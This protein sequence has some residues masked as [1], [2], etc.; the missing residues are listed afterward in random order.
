MSVLFKKPLVYASVVLNSLWA[1]VLFKSSNMSMSLS[2]KYSH[3]PM[4]ALMTRSYSHVLTEM[5]TQYPAMEPTTQIY[6]AF[7]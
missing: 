6:S 1:Y 4:S 3:G 2:Y 7:G 5:A